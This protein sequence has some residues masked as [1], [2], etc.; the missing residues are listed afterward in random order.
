MKSPMSQSSHS[1]GS[2]VLFVQGLPLIVSKKSV[3]VP[4]G[5]NLKIQNLH[6]SLSGQ[7][8]SFLL[9]FRSQGKI[10]P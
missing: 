5:H 1:A 4:G 10:T 7:F 3:Q 6:F 8:F 2:H 9:T